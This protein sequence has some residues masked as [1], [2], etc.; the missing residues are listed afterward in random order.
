[1]INVVKFDYSKLLGK[2]KEIFGTREN[3]VKEISI[4]STSLNLR[5]NNQ[6]KFDQRDILELCEALGISEEEIP[7]YFFTTKVRKT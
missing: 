3:L 7:V 2:I 6:L 5:L 1:M 4:S